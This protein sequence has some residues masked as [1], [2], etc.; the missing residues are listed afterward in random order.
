MKG[1][2]TCTCKRIDD[3]IWEIAWIEHGKMKS[4]FVR[5]KE[6]P[7]IL[8]FTQIKRLRNVSEIEVRKIKGIVP[9]K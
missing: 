3:E 8:T 9:K 5:S 7:E 4:K 2:V 6:K 1:I